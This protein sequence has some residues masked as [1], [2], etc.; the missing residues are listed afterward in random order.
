MQLPLIN[1]VI[2]FGLISTGLGA[3]IPT[4]PGESP[5]SEIIDGLKPISAQ[6]CYYE[7]AVGCSKGGHCFR[8][9]GE[10]KGNGNWCWTVTSSNGWKKCKKDA[11]TTDAAAG[12][13]RIAVAAVNTHEC[14]W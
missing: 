1:A 11:S 2:A 3:G 12:I 5:S 8:Q 13:A 7:K 6:A 9:C 14:G 10:P 4:A